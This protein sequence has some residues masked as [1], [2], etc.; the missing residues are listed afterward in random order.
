[1]EARLYPIHISSFLVKEEGGLRKSKHFRPGTNNPK[2]R[3]E[4]YLTEKGI[5][6]HK[7]RKVLWTIF[8]VVI[9]TAGTASTAFAHG[10]IPD[11]KV[12]LC[13]ATASGSNPF[14]IQNVDG[15]S[16]LKTSG[17]DSHS[18]DIIPSFWYWHIGS[19]YYILTGPN[20]G[21]S[22]YDGKNLSTDYDGNTGAEIL[23]NGCESPF[24][25]PEPKT[26]YSTDCTGVKAQD[27]VWEGGADGG[28]VDDG[29][30]YYIHEWSDP[31]TIETW[32][33][34][35]EPSECYTTCTATIKTGP[36]GTSSWY[37][38]GSPY[39]P[40]DWVD[41]GDGTFTRQWSQDQWK[42]YEYRWVDKYDQEHI[43]S[44]TTGHY[45]R[46]IQIPETKDGS[47]LYKASG[48]CKGATLYEAQLD[49]DGKVI[50]FGVIDT[51]F[52][53]DPYVL[54]SHEFVGD[55]YDLTVN[56][57]AKCQQ[58]HETAV[59]SNF[60]CDQYWGGYILDGNK[61][62]TF[63]GDWQDKFGPESVDMVVEVPTNVGELYGQTEFKITVDKSE[64]CIKCKIT[65]LYPMASYIDSGAP[66]GY[67]QGPFGQGAGVCNVIHPD[68]QTPSLER[69]QV[70]CSLCSDQIDGG[71]LYTPDREFFDGWVTKVTCYKDGSYHTHYY[72]DGYRWDQYVRLGQ[73]DDQGN[74]TCSRQNG[75]ADEIH[76][77]IHDAE[78]TQ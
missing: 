46:T 66:E 10:S 34:F 57:P 68:G 43:C 36:F 52:W 44:T 54:E 3:A 67:W 26:V 19:H 39:D 29:D 38:V 37:D 49:P 71:Y 76:Q 56:E 33:S 22:W 65:Q 40:T 35:T 75:C 13:H 23:A 42:D 20:I 14:T 77:M 53:T 7:I 1:M 62:E 31:A 24:T 6:M 55:G 28:W 18:G 72:Y 8:A 16:I 15:D 58:T 61:V 12:D 4:I 11:H 64:S 47:L 5:V 63:R 27:Q 21:A 45:T 51:F 41:N 30:P 59:Y 17:H 73:F 60:N 70:I 2:S 32:E 25:P 69:V 74:R 48:S 78:S 50:S 9:L